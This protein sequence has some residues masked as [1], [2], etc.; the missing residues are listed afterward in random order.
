MRV[1]KCVCGWGGRASHAGWLLGP[2]KPQQLTTCSTVRIVYTGKQIL[3]Q[4]AIKCDD[5]LRVG[6]SDSVL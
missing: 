1:Y 2:I 3:L 5:V 6:R 4:Q